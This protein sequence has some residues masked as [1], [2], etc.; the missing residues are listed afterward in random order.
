M[1]RLLHPSET[2]PAIQEAAKQGVLA[3]AGINPHL[4]AEPTHVRVSFNRAEEADMCARLITIS[5]VDGYS[6]EGTYPTY[7]EA[8]RVVW[9]L[10]AMS[11]IGIDA[12]N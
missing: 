9:N 7:E 11:F 4:V 8:H 2:G 12:Q 6:V 5:R 3:K 1:G 10:M